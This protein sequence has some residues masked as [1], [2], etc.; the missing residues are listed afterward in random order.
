MSNMRWLDLFVV[1]G[2]ILG[3]T[4]LGLRFSK[5]QTSTETYFVAKRAI[6]SWAMGMSILAT[7]ITSVT[8]IAY[9]GSSYAKDWSLLVPGFLVVGVLIL[10]GAIVIPF[11]RHAVGMSCYEYFG[12]RFGR[13]TRVYASIAFALGHFSKMGFVFY[14][15]GLTI[16]SMTGWNMDHVIIIGGILT[17]LYTYLGG[18]EAVIWTDVVQGVLLW[19]GVFVCLGYLLFTPPGG[20]SAVLHLAAA[21]HKFSLGSLSFDLSKPTIPVLIIYGFFWYLQ[22]YTADQPIVQ[23]YLVAKSDRAAIKGVTL[24]ALLCVPVW[25]LFMLVGTCLWAFYQLTGDKLPS[26]I[27]K[28]DQ[29]FPYFLS[30]QLPPGLAG[31]FMAALMGAAMCALASDLNAFAVVGVEDIYRLIRPV[32][33]DSQRLRMG[34]YLVAACGVFCIL[35]ALVLAHTNGSALSLWF[36]VSAIASGGLAGLFLLAF[37]SPRA[38]TSGVYAGIIAS[39]IFTAWATVTLSGKRLIDMGRFNFPWHD[40]MIGAIAHVILLVVGYAAS[41]MLASGAEESGKW[42]EMTLGAWLRKRRH[43]ADVANTLSN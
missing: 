11:Y 1:C 40:Y 17:I 6:P 22:K 20:P 2:Y 18:L 19:V 29:I 12:R 41:R 31:I 16:S 30:T 27:T 8:F 4:I 35:T 14:L 28:S 9:P 3:L 24:G 21:N 7:L 37:L 5:R 32:S 15:L 38:N 25:T 26:Y 43:H 36:T 13:P 34:R 10:V 42:S 39:L 23:R 33:T